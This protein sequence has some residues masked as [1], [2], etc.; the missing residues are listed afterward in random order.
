MNKTVRGQINKIAKPNDVVI[1]LGAGNITK[2]SDKIIHQLDNSGM[3]NAEKFSDF[4]FDIQGELGE[5][6]PLA[7]L[8]PS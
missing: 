3:N 8:T 1:F 2:W 7:S 5:N 4:Y 6:Y